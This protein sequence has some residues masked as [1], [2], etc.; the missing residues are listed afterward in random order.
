MEGTVLRPGGVGANLSTAS[1]LRPGSLALGTM[2]VYK[3]VA[4]SSSGFLVI[5][6]T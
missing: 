5:M 1:P 6:G 2:P 3:N 4:I